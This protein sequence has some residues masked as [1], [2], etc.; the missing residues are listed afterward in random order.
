MKIAAFFDL[1]KTLITINSGRSW[2]EWERRR[3]RVSWR[4]MFQAAT[5]FGLYRLSFI[6]M[7]E[8]VGLAL[9]VYEGEP[10]ER[11]RDWTREWY[12]AHVRSTV[13]P[14][15]WPV[16]S[17]HRDA[18]HLLVLHTLSSPYEAALVKEHLDLHAALSSIYEVVDGHMTG[19][20]VPP[21]C[22]GEGKVHKAEAFA[23]EQGV[24]LERSF[25]YSDSHTDLPMLLRVGNPRVVNPDP[26][27]RYEARRR[28]WPILN[29]R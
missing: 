13:A 12:D 11:I 22:Y 5:R 8:A 17:W 27:L 16:L 19:T 3:G 4:Q 29:W 2:V 9:R 26:R 25:F 21:L 15:A 28:N 6:D 7:E 1:D 14:G 18:G 10:E 23:R 20:F 24:D